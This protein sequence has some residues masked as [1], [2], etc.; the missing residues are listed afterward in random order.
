MVLLKSD[1]NPLQLHRSTRILL[2]AEQ[3]RGEKVEATQPV[4]ASVN[5]NGQKRLFEKR[6][7]RK[8]THIQELG[9]S[10]GGIQAEA[11]APVRGG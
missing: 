3:K 2:K 1:L 8:D 6:H 10:G 5:V 4:A 9:A 7:Q 11:V